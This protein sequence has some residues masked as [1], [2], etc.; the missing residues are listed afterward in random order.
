MSNEALI[1]LDTLKFT[2]AI[3]RIVGK[4]PEYSA[5]VVSDVLALWCKDLMAST[6]PTNKFGGRSGSHRWIGENAIQTDLERIFTPID[7]PRALAAWRNDNNYGESLFRTSYGGLVMKIKR[8]LLN[9][10]IDTWHLEHQDKRTGRT[11]EPKS[12]SANDAWY[13]RMPVPRDALISYAKKVKQRVGRTKAGWIPGVEYFCAKTEGHVKPNVR[14]CGGWV[15]RHKGFGY[16][17]GGY[18]LTT[19]PH[20][21]T[22]KG[23]AFN[24]VPWLE[25]RSQGLIDSTQATR[26]FDLNRGWYAKRMQKFFNES[27]VQ[28]AAS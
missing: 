21:S 26:L 23:M 8:K 6:I 2:K 7:H 4:M 18:N 16:S 20:T 3:N 24:S 17:F 15:W 25:S 14:G 10:A 13:G 19:N 5:F 12:E 11:F 1:R 28:G 27:L 9:T 22:S